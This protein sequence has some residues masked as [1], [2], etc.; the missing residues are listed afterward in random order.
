MNSESDRKTCEARESGFRTM[1]DRVFGRF[2]TF[3]QS[4]LGIKMPDA[5]KT[6]LQA[7]LQKR[8]RKLAMTSFDEYCEYVFSPEGMREEL[9][10]MIDAVTTNKTDFFREAQHFTYLTDSVLP[11]LI[12]NFGIGHRRPARFWSAGCATGEEPYTL[13][14]VLNEFRAASSGFRFEILGTDVST[15]VLRSAALGIYSHEKVAPVPMPLRKKY[16]LKSRDRQKDLVRIIPELRRQVSFCRLNFMSGSFGV[17][18]MMDVVFCRNVLIYF[19]R[20]TQE[21]VLNRICRHLL[22]G[23]YLFTGHSETLSGLQV[24]LV[25]TTSTV[26]RKPV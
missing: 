15:Q 1:S 26:Y 17:Q 14:M 20:E 6:M 4:E 25:A 8:L 9:P 22:P 19:D 18:Q 10:N 11:E 24:P 5:K 2:R 7:R 3:I 23:G 16:L 12:R 13:A 21:A